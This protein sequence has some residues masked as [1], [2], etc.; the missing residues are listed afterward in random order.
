M[1][2][3]ER[4]GGDELDVAIGMLRF[5]QHD[6]RRLSN[7]SEGLFVDDVWHLADVAAVVPFQYVN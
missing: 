5:A 3:V 7:R 6:K 1:F 4:L 2:F